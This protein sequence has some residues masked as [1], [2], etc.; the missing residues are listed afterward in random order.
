MVYGFEAP[1]PFLRGCIEIENISDFVDRR[2]DPND[3]S[4]RVSDSLN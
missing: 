2:Y 3:I 4:V 1:E